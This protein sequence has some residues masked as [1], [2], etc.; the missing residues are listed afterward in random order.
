MARK[1]K[2]VKIEK[3]RD[4][5]KSFLITE[6]PIMKADQWAMRALFAL[7]KGGTDIDGIDPSGGMLEMAKVATSAIKGLN[8]D[9]GIEL[10]NEL[11]ECIKIVPSGGVSRDVLWD[12]DVE[13]IS[14]LF[15][16]RKE[17]L[18]LH[19]DFLTSGSSQDSSN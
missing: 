15:V 6:M 4:V 1:E 10:L 16:L 13:D 18:M 11:L 5:G 9:E 12:D 17:A 8:S 2:V 19:I 3:G 14:T 7:A